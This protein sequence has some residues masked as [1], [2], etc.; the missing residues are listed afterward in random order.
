MGFRDRPSKKHVIWTRETRNGVTKKRFDDEHFETWASHYGFDFEKTR[1]TDHERAEESRIQFR[2]VFAWGQTES[3]SFEFGEEEWE[4][5][6]QERPRT[7]IE[8]DEEGVAR[9]KGWRNE[10]LCDVAEMRFDG[11]TLF[12]RTTED[13]TKRVD[14]R[15]LAEK[16]ER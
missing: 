7:F 16:P 2:C 5:A 10:M 15:K 9:L 4:M 6:G 13:E 11:P 1:R 12:V 3:Q 8:I 14:A